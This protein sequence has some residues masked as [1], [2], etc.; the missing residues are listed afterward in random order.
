MFLSDGFY[1]MLAMACSASMAIVMCLFRTSEHNRYGMILGNYLTCAAVGFL[2]IADK[3]VLL[4]A[5]T[6]TYLCGIIGGALFVLSLV[7]IQ[8]GISLSGAILT[9][10]FSKL[11]LLV[12]LLL[13]IVVFHEQPTVLQAAGLAA[14]LLSFL[15]MNGS[16]KQKGNTHLFFLLIVLITNGMSDSMA[17]IY[18]TIGVQAE[19]TAYMFLVFLFSAVLTTFLLTA[20][21]VKTGK[22][23]AWKDLAAG[24]LIGIPNYFSAVF[25]LR[26]LRTIPAVIAYPVFSTGTI[27][28]VTAVS[29]VLF[30]ER[31]SRRQIA[32]LCLILVSLVLLNL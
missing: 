12:P 11:G 27:L 5:H 14:V 23:A 18:S 4:Y 26:A 13:S 7:C 28:I 21:T 17:K 30:H 9:S 22:K 24:I 2:L 1:L 10:A 6:A 31:L 15:I 8:S 29:Y 3:S 25:L 32:G 16:P 19:E 20:E